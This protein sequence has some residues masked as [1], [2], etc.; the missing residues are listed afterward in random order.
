[1]IVL[2]QDDYPDCYGDPEFIGKVGVVHS[3]AVT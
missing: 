1:M 3:I 2:C